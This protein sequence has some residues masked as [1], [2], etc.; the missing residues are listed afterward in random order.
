MGFRCRTVTDL[1]EERNGTAAGTTGG[2]LAR[3]DGVRAV[4]CTS[5]LGPVWTLDVSVG[6]SLS[7]LARCHR[8]VLMKMTPAPHACRGD[9]GS[10]SSRRASPCGCVCVCVCVYYGTQTLEFAGFSVKAGARGVP[11]AGFATRALSFRPLAPNKQQLQL[12]PVLS[13]LQLAL[14]KRR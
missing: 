11:R 4:A 9:V 1:G 5:P 10:C 3:R 13:G 7:T 12:L 14:P 6:R 8:T 2:R